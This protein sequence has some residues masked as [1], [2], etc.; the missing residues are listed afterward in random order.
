M[1]LLEVSMKKEGDISGI[2][3][4]EREAMGAHKGKQEVSFEKHN[5]ICH[6][7]TKMA[8]FDMLT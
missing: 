6:R 8:V 4:S 5:Q 3:I 2:M 7:M 1:A